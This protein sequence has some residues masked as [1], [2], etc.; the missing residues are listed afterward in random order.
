MEQ[1]HNSLSTNQ[2]LST[3]LITGLPVTTILN[4]GMHPYADTFVAEHQLVLSE[5]VLPLQC[6]L[7]PESGS[8]QLKYV[9]NDWDR[10]NLYRYSYTSSNGAYSRD[11]WDQFAQQMQ[12]TLDLR[13]KRV[14]EIGCNDG[15][16]LQQ[17]MPHSA[18]LGIDTS[19]YMC[20]LSRERGI[21]V[22]HMVF[23][24]AQAEILACQGTADLIIA[25]NVFNH[26]N[27][28]VDF[29]LGVKELLSPNGWFVFEVPS[30]AWMMQSGRY[31]MIYHEHVSY[32]TVKSLHQLLTAAGLQIHQI[33][34]VDYHG[35]S[36]R[37]WAQHISD[38]MVQPAVAEFIAQETQ[39][40]LFD[41][42][43]YHK[44]QADISQRRNQM[45][46][47]LLEIRITAPSVPIIAVGAAAK[48][49]TFLNYHSITPEIVQYVTDSSP[50]KQGKYTPLSR[51]PIVSDEIFGQ[52][53]HAYALI[54]SWNISEALRENLLSINN[55]IEFISL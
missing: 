47:R 35:V 4:L 2:L 42:E 48:G 18:V 9:S 23:T 19:D 10:Y 33:Q 52:Y 8:I 43:F 39:A 27:D 34:Q 55:N 12:D 38:Q 30:W 20:A 49:N 46:R 13:H 24:Q 53:D 1:E 5:P 37:V 29:A 11:H 25:N 16:L 40:G 26:A 6:T 54:L 45:L 31:D 7:C 21:P 50:L 36:L 32:F 14:I 44:F 17:F 51:I 15:Y 22:E 3:C 28:P 41:P